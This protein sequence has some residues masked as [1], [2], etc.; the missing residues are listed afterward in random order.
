MFETCYLAVDLTFCAKDDLLICF[1]LDD[2]PFSFLVD[3]FCFVFPHCGNY[4]K[5]EP[6]NV[7]VIQNLSWHCFLLIDFFVCRVSI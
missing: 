6:C 3:L 1:Y 4:L 7:F 2:V 5:N